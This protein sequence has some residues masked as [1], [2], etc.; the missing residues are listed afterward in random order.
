M[1][2]AKVSFLD[3]LDRKTLLLAGGTLLLWAVAFAVAASGWDEFSAG[4]SLRRALAAY[5]E[6]RF[7][8]ALSESQ[9]AG[10]LLPGYADAELLTLAVKGRMGESPSGATAALTATEHPDAALGEALERAARDAP[11]DPA[12]LVNLAAFWARRG[13]LD[14]AEGFL[15]KALA[16]RETEAAG[17]RPTV[18]GLL[19]MAVLSE[20]RGRLADAARHLAQAR[21]VAGRAGKPAGAADLLPGRILTVEVLE[22]RMRLLTEMAAGT[23]SEKDL[24]AAEALVRRAE[25]TAGVDGLAA[26]RLASLVGVVALRDG[27]R[28]AASRA[29][30]EGMFAAAKRLQPDAARDPAAALNA[31][32]LSAG[33]RGSLTAAAGGTSSSWRG[34]YR[35]IPS[36]RIPPRA[37]A[38]ADHNRIV[39]DYLAGEGIDVTVRGLEGVVARFPESP[40]AWRNLGVLYEEM[41]LPGKAADCYA[42]AAGD[43]DQADAAARAE[44]LR[45]GTR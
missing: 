34:V 12:P 5:E 44:A 19:G 35:G 37:A 3:L 2:R 45:G 23:L 14:R 20:R 17:W 26:S 40:V 43:P 31:L 27:A 10:R 30:C 33:L 32:A 28:E 6:G 7:L 1:S 9:A 41:D 22:A 8:E 18:E 25:E 11:R 4:W 42:R 39:L 13:D 29:R 16:G 24:S 21:W 36:G 15:R 38:A